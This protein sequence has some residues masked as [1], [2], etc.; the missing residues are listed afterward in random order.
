MSLSV[1]FARPPEKDEDQFD[2]IL[3]STDE[4]GVPV[5]PDVAAG[6]VVSVLG[7]YCRT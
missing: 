5:L 6:T 4:D 7:W 2:G 3:H 1:H